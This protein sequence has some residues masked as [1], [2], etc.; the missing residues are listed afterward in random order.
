MEAVGGGFSELGGANWR[1]S[2][3]GLERELLAVAVNKKRVGFG[4][5]RKKKKMN[6]V[7]VVDLPESGTTP[8]NFSPKNCEH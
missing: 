5:Y 7:L 3:V 6:G 4:D 8:V 1:W 2:F